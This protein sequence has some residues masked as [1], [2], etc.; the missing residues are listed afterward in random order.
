MLEDLKRQGGDRGLGADQSP[1][2]PC[3]YKC[4]G[5]MASTFCTQCKKAMCAKHEKVKCSNSADKLSH[6]LSSIEPVVIV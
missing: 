6:H 3:G 5:Q 4:D 2:E 1:G